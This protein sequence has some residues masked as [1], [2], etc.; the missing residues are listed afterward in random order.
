MSSGNN[1][2]EANLDCGVGAVILSGGPVLVGEGVDAIRLGVGQPASCAN[3]PCFR[4]QHKQPHGRSN[5]R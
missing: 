3:P 4:V 2:C 1:R 5:T